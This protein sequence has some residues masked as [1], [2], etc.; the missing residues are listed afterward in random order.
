[1]LI[2]IVLICLTTALVIL[3]VSDVADYRRN[4]DIF[5]STLFLDPVSRLCPLPSPPP[6]SLFSLVR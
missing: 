5:W 6:L 4:L 2:H 3:I 1:M